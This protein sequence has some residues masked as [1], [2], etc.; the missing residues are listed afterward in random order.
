MQRWNPVNH[1]TGSDHPSHLAIYRR[2]AIA[3][4]LKTLEQFPVDVP[5]VLSALASEF[6]HWRHAPT[7]AYK[8]REK[9]YY[10]NHRRP[11]PKAI[12]R[13]A[14]ALVQP[15]LLRRLREQAA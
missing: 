11:I 5:F 13:R 1:L 12:R 10:I 14:K 6:G 2:E 9:E 4:D 7:I 8:R 3:A 15:I